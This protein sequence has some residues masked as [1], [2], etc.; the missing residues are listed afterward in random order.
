MASED[1]QPV[2][3]QGEKVARQLSVL[4]DRLRSTGMDFQFGGKRDLSEQ[5]GYKDD[6]DFD[7]FYERYQR[8]GLAAAI[9]DKPAR[10]TWRRRPK[11]FPPG[12]EDGE[13]QKTVTKIW[14]RV[15][16]TSV[17]KRADIMQRIGQYSV[18]FIGAR[19]TGALNTPIASDG[20][21]PPEDILFLTP[22][23]ENDVRVVEV[24]E[25]KSDPRFGAP[26]LYEIDFFDEDDFEHVEVDPNQKVHASRIIHVAEGGLE[27]EFFSAPALERVWNFL[28]DIDKIGGG[29]AEMFWQNVSPIFHGEIPDD[30]DVEDDDQMT[31]AEDQLREALL[32]LR[33][34]LITQGMDVDTVAGPTPDP[35]GVF[36]VL[37]ALIAASDIMPQRVLF[38]A[39]EG[40]LASTEDKAS[41]L[42]SVRERQEQFAEPVVVRPF[43]RRLQAMGTL[44]RSAGDDLEVFWPDLFELTELEKAEVAQRRAR[45]V[46]TIAPAGATDLLAETPELRQVVGLP[47]REVDGPGQ[48][49]QDRGDRMEPMEVDREVAGA[50]GN[51]D[52]TERQIARR[53]AAHR[54]GNINV[55]DEPQDGLFT[56][57]Q[58][59]A[60]YLGN[61]DNPEEHL[62]STYQGS[63]NRYAW[64]VADGPEANRAR[65]YDADNLEEA[66][67]DM[68]DLVI[69]NRLPHLMVGKLIGHIDDSGDEVDVYRHVGVIGVENGSLEAVIRGRLGWRQMTNEELG[70]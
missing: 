47:E 12:E 40:E 18:V 22:F 5:L 15:D 7:D 52:A 62:D 44:E 10:A 55:T 26:E 65:T 46:R 3:E 16:A 19:N 27:S 23:M 36:E 34:V 70:Q 49:I 31:Q 32:G 66:M 64:I 56:I 21:V 51:T 69:D 29:S 59:R 20:E 41:F 45:A 63:S 39:E 67:S 54:E 17:F 61:P 35:R 37:K 60:V 33:R 58:G 50:T 24:V 38:G 9:V 4:V 13:F 8:N 57:D 6:L 2:S 30:Y 53:R 68:A 28:D 43:I 25:D 48:S 1:E 14:N 11:I 42:E